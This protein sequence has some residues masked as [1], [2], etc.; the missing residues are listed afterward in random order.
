MMRR[1]VIA[2]TVGLGMVVPFV[3]AL[4]SRETPSAQAPARDAFKEGYQHQK[5][6]RFKEA[7]CSYEES[8]REDPQQAEALNN[9]GFCYKNL[10]EYDKAIGYYQRA[11]AINPK[12]AEAHEYLGE[13]YLGLGKLELATQ[14]YETL[15]TLN[16]QEARELKDRIDVFAKSS[17]R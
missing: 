10:K 8:I 16:P 14:E 11:L 7:I 2:V 9:L 12:L 1:S 13:A 4:P 15:R 17:S 6:K 3:W 5:A